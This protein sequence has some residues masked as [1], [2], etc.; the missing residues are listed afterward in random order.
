[1]LIN[2]LGIEGIASNGG[3]ASVRWS[4]KGSHE[5]GHLYPGREGANV[6]FS[7]SKF[8]QQEDADSAVE[9][10]AKVCAAAKA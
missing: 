5:I 8:T 9:V 6:R 7:L 4:N 3:S 1:M 2:N 10:M